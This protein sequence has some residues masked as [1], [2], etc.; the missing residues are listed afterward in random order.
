MHLPGFPHPPCTRASR[1]SVTLYGTRLPDPA[2]PCE[3]LSVAP[4]RGALLF[5]KF[6]DDQFRQLLLMLWLPSRRHE[7][8]GFE[9]A[10]MELL[11]KL[12][13]RL[14]FI[15]NCSKI[16]YGITC[17]FLAFMLDILARCSCATVGRPSGRS[18]N[19]KN[20]FCVDFLA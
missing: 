17:R 7:P 2:I 4:H 6:I 20:M 9:I 11:F 5:D 19:G 1:L 8:G 18:I 10:T 13:H 14:T 12:T 16:R 15:A 3:G